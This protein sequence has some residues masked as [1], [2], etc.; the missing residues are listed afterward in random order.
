MINRLLRAAVWG[1]LSL[2]IANTASADFIADQAALDKAES[3]TGKPASAEAAAAKKPVDQLWVARSG[4]SVRKILTEWGKVAGWTIRWEATDLDYPNLATRTFDGDFES[5]VR[6]LFA[7]Y[8][9]ADR[10]LQVEGWR[11]NSVIVIT[12]KK[13]SR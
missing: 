9:Y 7:P 12:E 8:Q 6:G 5:A 2:A 13:A 11:G 10:P 1:L 4:A 3:R